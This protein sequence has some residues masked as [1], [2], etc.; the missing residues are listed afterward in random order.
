M[1]IHLKM[2]VCSVLVFYISSAQ[3]CD[4]FD[5]GRDALSVFDQLKYYIDN[6]QYTDSID[7]S[8]AT[9]YFP[10]I[11]II[12]PR[13]AYY[14]SR[15]S[16]PMAVA[17]YVG[18][19]DY[20][21]ETNEVIQTS[22]GAVT[23]QFLTENIF[24]A[25]SMAITGQTLLEFE[26]HINEY[27]YL[28][29][30]EYIEFENMDYNTDEIGKFIKQNLG[31]SSD[32]LGAYFTKEL[33]AEVTIYTMIIDLFCD[34]FSN[35]T[36]S[37]FFSQFESRIYYFV[38]LYTSFMFRDWW[39]FFQTTLADFNELENIWTYTANYGVTNYVLAVTDSLSIL[40][41]WVRSHL[42]Y[43]VK[44][45]YE[46]NYGTNYVLLDKP[47]WKQAKDKIKI[48]ESFE[49]W[50]YVQYDNFM[51]FFESNI[52]QPINDFLD[53]IG[54]SF[55]DFL[56]QVYGDLE[57]MDKFLLAITSW[58]WIISVPFRVIEAIYVIDF[59]TC[60]FC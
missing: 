48:L 37:N 15:L 10:W 3:S 13:H 30:G 42:R 31:L 16:Q 45:G 46:L 59:S 11:D 8:I 60:F 43:L 44:L 27:W 56:E 2:R 1:G 39:Q 53:Q 41:S 5:V 36:L 54:F 7:G 47:L 14:R 55:G 33:I 25:K 29:D 21:V 4:P 50:Y 6:C 52:Q 40:H 23:S 28:G 22:F 19:S 12:L 9:K 35:L 26:H 24:S 51:D 57:I 38:N 20:A 49:D 18:I 17:T 58:T 32:L 34:I